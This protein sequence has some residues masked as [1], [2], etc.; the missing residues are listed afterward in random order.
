MAFLKW[1]RDCPIE[2]SVSY[3]IFTYLEMALQWHE[4]R[5]AHSN[6]VLDLKVHW[7]QTHYDTCIVSNIILGNELHENENLKFSFLRCWPFKWL[8][9]INEK[10]FEQLLMYHF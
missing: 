3:Y 9:W 10:V 1:Q 8:K 7:N 4:T 6:G 5:Y 2:S